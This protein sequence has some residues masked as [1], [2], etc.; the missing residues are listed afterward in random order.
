MEP[1]AVY[2][3]N[4]I[5]YWRPIVIL[6]SVVAGFMISMALYHGKKGSN[7]YVMALYFPLALLLS[8]I[9]GRILHWYCHIEQYASFSKALTD[10]SKG[11]FL[12]PGVLM[13]V[14]LVAF[15][16]A[17]FTW[18]RSHLELL[19]VIAPGFTFTLAMI[20]LADSF[21]D[22][23]RG[24]MLVN[25]KAFQ[26]LPF[27]VAVKDNA[28]N[29]EYRF[30]TFMISFLLL[31]IIMMLLLVFYVK[32]QKWEKKEP[33][34]AY[35]NTF[36]MFLALYGGME[37]VIDST[38][39][40]A[41]H[42]YFPGEAL[43]NLNKGASFMGLSQFLGAIFFVYVIT[44]YLAMA[45]KANKTFK[46]NIIP[47]IMFIVGIGVGGVSEYLVQRYSG[48]YLLWYSTQTLGVLVVIASIFWVY[49][50]CI[51]WPPKATQANAVGN[52]DSIEQS[53]GDKTTMGI[54][55][56]AKKEGMDIAVDEDLD[57][58]LMELD[59]EFEEDEFDREIEEDSEKSKEADSKEDITDSN[60]DSEKD[61]E[62]D[63]D[64]SNA[65]DD[66]ENV[67]DKEVTKSDDTDNQKSEDG[68]AK[69][70]ETKKE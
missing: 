33:L 41:A 18:S 55:E 42:L 15:A 23:C 28:G 51:N 12:I 56:A 27:A 34:K 10:F 40:D 45:T 44:Y 53:K 58:I 61:S 11:D 13:A 4:V 36:R 49:S 29:V 50:M 35:G 67:A 46:K 1:I 70:V 19:D 5:I 60:D 20:R 57:R 32:D 39:Y 62:K 3:E 65:S 31:L 30:A 59:K 52:V 21:T 38:R 37:V 22:A 17:P 48:M 64:A 63:S 24:K 47:L 25:N 14:W 7:R 43:A 16:V 68:N 26:V 54:V 2:Y 6:L 9:L 69:E 66:K 8:L